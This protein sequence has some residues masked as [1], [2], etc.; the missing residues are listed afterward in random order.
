MHSCVRS[1]DQNNSSVSVL[2][3]YSINSF[4]EASY[5]LICFLWAD[6]SIDQSCMYLRAFNYIDRLALLPPLMFLR[7]FSMYWYGVFPRCCFFIGNKKKKLYWWFCVGCMHRMEMYSLS[8]RKRRRWSLRNS[9]C[10]R[11]SSQTPSLVRR[12]WHNNQSV[13][14]S[15]YRYRR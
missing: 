13:F 15:L 12:R 6:Q 5:S 14:Y 11:S 2:A 9:R 3:R 8:I 1:K 7:F 4:S 10:F